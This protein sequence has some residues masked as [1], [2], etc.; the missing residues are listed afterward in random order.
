MCENT[1]FQTRILLVAAVCLFFAGGVSQAAVV[2]I[3]SSADTYVD[4]FTPFDNYG[5]EMRL[6]VG[7][8]T[9]LE[10][11]SRCRSYLKF[12]LSVIPA[13]SVI[14]NATLELEAVSYS[15]S[16]PPIKIAVH[17]VNDVAWNEATLSWSMSPNEG[18][19]AFN[20]IETDSVLVSGIGAVQWNV[21]QDV[22]VAFNSVGLYSTLV[23]LADD[24]WQA[25]QNQFIQFRARE[26]SMPAM[27]SVEY[28]PP[29]I[30]PADPDGGGEVTAVLIRHQEDEH[31]TLDLLRGEPHDDGEPGR[32]LD[33]SWP[34]NY[35]YTEKIHIT[36][37]G[38]IGDRPCSIESSDG[39]QPAKK[40]GDFS[41]DSLG[42]LTDGWSSPDG[43]ADGGV[44]IRLGYDSPGNLTAADVNYADGSKLSW[45]L[46][47]D[48]DDN[49]FKRV[50]EKADYSGAVPLFGGTVDYFLRNVNPEQLLYKT[51]Q[52]ASRATMLYN[53]DD[54]DRLISMTL[55][56]GTYVREYGYYGGGLL[57]EYSNHEDSDYNSALHYT[58]DRVTGFLAKIASASN[59]T[60]AEHVLLGQLSMSY[61]DNGTL[62]EV[63][64]S[65]DEDAADIEPVFAANYAYDASDRLI[66]AEY[67]SE[68]PEVPDIVIVMD[69]DKTASNYMVT[70]YIY[71]NSGR[72][73]WTIDTR[74]NV[75]RTI[76]N[77][78]ALFADKEM[79]QVHVKGPEEPYVTSFE[80]DAAGTTLRSTDLRGRFKQYEYD[81][82]GN[83]FDSFVL[84]TRSDHDD[85]YRK[86]FTMS[87]QA[88]FEYPPDPSFRYGWDQ[89]GD[90]EIVLEEGEVGFNGG[91]AVRVKSKL[92]RNRD[93]ELRRIGCKNIVIGDHDGNC[94]INAND[95]AIFA[96]NW[97]V[98][99]SDSM[100]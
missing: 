32:V 35:S 51:V 22:V 46:G 2:T 39:N 55:G 75:T 58:Y 73:A 88:G 79:A 24:E 64:Y 13:G 68:D 65:T 34:P 94:K 18:P 14:D 69:P 52:G 25:D 78:S 100:H 77:R 12:D 47:Y 60:D 9:V 53:Y 86:P 91:T 89:Y 84:G 28:S 63:G 44:G 19:A 17:F 98:D 96:A 41:Y 71:D 42:R 6:A 81:E 38:Y 70:H 93:A 66:R 8:R 54:A 50:Y 20:L 10:E 74:G 97:M 16:D 3:N 57:A 92:S 99:E 40:T 80:N 59:L 83:H 33:L 26:T 90:P 87:A 37:L 5:T 82:D 48:A 36:Y 1:G 67:E 76:Y 11:K 29:N 31:Y 27:L 4:G 61:Y 56:D 72:L 7:F 23:K 30:G 45:T 62:H 21:T 15:I 85:G 95:F 49:V 43:S